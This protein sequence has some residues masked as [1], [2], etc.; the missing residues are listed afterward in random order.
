[1]G[2]VGLGHQEAI[3]ADLS[4][5]ASAGSATMNGNELANTRAT[6]YYG[7]RFL[8]GELQILRG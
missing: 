3:I 5:A 1:M 8:S 2:D 4:K 6:A 7:F